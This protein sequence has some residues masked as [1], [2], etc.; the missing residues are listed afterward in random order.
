M[1]D[2][3]LSRFVR[4]ALVAAALYAGAALP[5]AAQVVSPP[6]P[7]QH[8]PAS[9]YIPLRDAFLAT[10]RANGNTDA[11]FA[12]ASALQRLRMGD[13]A[14]A[15]RDAG[16]AMLDAGKVPPA[17]LKS[18]L[19]QPAP[20]LPATSLTAPPFP[21]TI[22][23]GPGVPQ[24]IETTAADA[25]GALSFARSEIDLAETRVGHPIEPARAAYVDATASL[26][27]NDPAAA[28]TAARKAAGL[29]LDAYMAGR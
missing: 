17:T 7:P 10:L 2:A 9:L 1:G 13:V 3:M 24:K 16:Q 21:M 29:A 5:A 14:G 27:R 12:Y 26:E 4:G 19:A 25:Q 23:P 6:G 28:V 11:S 20:P 8:V 15:Q 22:A 18:A